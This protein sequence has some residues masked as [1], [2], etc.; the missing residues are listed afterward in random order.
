MHLV[1]VIK[2]TI[3]YTKLVLQTCRH[4]CF[5]FHPVKT[6][7]TAEGGAVTTNIGNINRKLRLIKIIIF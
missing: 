6:I 4:K 3:K 2:L 1:Q 7:T 5:F